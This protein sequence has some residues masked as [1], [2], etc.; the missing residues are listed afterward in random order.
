MNILRRIWDVLVG[1]LMIALSAAFQLLF[2]VLLCFPAFAIID[3]LGFDPKG[4]WVQWACIGG[5][6]IIF[7][8]IS[9]FDYFRRRVANN[10]L[11]DDASM[12]FLVPRGIDRIFF[13][14]DRA[15]R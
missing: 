10:G 2:Y 1:T 9:C 15:A 13:G 11:G 4:P 8:S 7:N 6:A 14:V 3:W 12:F 5:F